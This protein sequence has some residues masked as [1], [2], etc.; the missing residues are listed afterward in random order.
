VPEYVFSCFNSKGGATINLP[1]LFFDKSR[2]KYLLIFCEFSLEISVFRYD[3][4]M[5]I[6]ASSIEL[7]ESIIKGL[8][9][10]TSLSR[11]VKFLSRK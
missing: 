7:G 11:I 2:I 3:L 6:D 4:C 5:H 9:G 8:I 10:I 1:V